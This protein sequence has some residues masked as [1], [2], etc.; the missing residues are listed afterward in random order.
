MCASFSNI[1]VNITTN[2]A[3]IFLLSGLHEHEKPMATS[4]FVLEAAKLNRL[5]F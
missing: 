1:Y 2:N 5:E 4:L 3:C